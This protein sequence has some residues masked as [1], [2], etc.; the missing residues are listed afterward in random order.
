MYEFLGRLLYDVELDRVAYQF[1]DIAAQVI[2]NP[3]NGV[4][5][6]KSTKNT[7]LLVD[8]RSSS[9]SSHECSD[10]IGSLSIINAAFADEHTLFYTG[11]SESGHSA[12]FIDARTFQLLSKVQSVVPIFYV[13]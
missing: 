10:A 6:A 1:P 12:G 2:C 3:F 7:I 4:F 13:S 9:I 8:P 5:F 11:R